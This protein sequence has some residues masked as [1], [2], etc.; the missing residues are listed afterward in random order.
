MQIEFVF[1]WVVVPHSAVVGSERFVLPP[2]SRLQTVSNRHPEHS[3]M[4]CDKD[5]GKIVL[6]LN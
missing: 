4:N 5:E 2:S 3:D 6:M 1:L